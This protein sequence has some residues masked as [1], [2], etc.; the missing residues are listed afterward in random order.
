MTALDALPSRALAERA[1]DATRKDGTF[2]AAVAQHDAIM[3]QP[4]AKAAL[5][6]LSDARR[7]KLPPVDLDRTLRLARAG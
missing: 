4:D 1:L 6:I 5:A 7:R 2:S 3:R